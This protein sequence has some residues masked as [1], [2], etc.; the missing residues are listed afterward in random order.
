MT[1]T[2]ESATG[3]RAAGRHSDD[4]YRVRAI[5]AT[6][7]FAL[8]LPCMVLITVFA[9]SPPPKHPW[10]AAAMELDVEPQVISTGEAVFKS[11]CAVCHGRDAR[12]IARLGKPLRNSAFVQEHSDDELF[13]LISEGRLPSSPENTTGTV[14]PARGNQGLS[15]D[16]LSNVIVYLRAIQ[17]PSQPT[18]SLDDWIVESNVAAGGAQV[19]GLVGATTGVG[20]DLFISACSACH[21]P[22]GEGM[23]GLGKPLST[24]EFVSA[25][26]DDELIKFIKMGRP[27]WDAENTT[28]VDMPPKGGNPALNDEQLADI[29]KYIRALHSQPAGK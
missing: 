9:Q 20:H 3:N 29:V 13:A 22:S 6:I 5:G 16:Q 2:I 10:H 27:I 21:G 17:D 19:A 14:M 25:K 1:A 8:T 24:S 12:G 11:T 23:E 4:P 7:M 18:V 26:T 15:D 28:G